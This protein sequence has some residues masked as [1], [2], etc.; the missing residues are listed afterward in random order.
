MFSID[1]L[2]AQPPLSLIF[3]IFLIFG[4]DFIGLFLLKKF[5]LIN[6]K[7]LE[8][9]RYQAPIVGAMLL[10]IIF[11]P[12][13]LVNLTPRLFFQVNA[14][15]LIILGAFQILY[16]LGPY[17]LFLSRVNRF[18]R[19]VLVMSFTRK[20]LFFML[21]GMALLAI[22]P[23]TH[24]DALDYHTGVAI[25]IL[26]NGGMPVMPEWFLSR[27]AGNGELLNAIS[28]SVGAE[29]FSSLLQYSSLLSMLSIIFFTRKI[30]WERVQSI[31]SA[32]L[33][34]ILL[35]LTS[36]PILL[37]LISSSKPQLWPIAMIFFGF[38]LTIH[39]YIYKTSKYNLL[40]TYC[41][42]CML[43]MTASQAKFN[44]M[45]DGAIIGLLGF[46]LMI[47][48]RY[49]FLALIIS[50][51]AV[52]IILVPPIIWKAF[53]YNSS[54]IDS[55]LH[56]LP[57]HLPGTDELMRIIQYSSDSDSYFFFPI[58]IMIPSSP[59]TLGTML[60]IGCLLFFALRPEKYS[61]LKY[62]VVAALIVIILNVFLGPRSARSYLAPYIW[63]LYILSLQ[64]KKLYLKKY[65]WLKWP[66]YLQAFVTT[67]SVYYGVLI[68]TPGAFISAWRT[69]I[70]EL[71]APGYEVMKWAD[72][73]LPKNAVLLNTHRSMALSPRD[74]V[75][76]E[77]GYTFLGNAN[78]NLN[79]ARSK[80]YV[81]R[82]KLKN[83]DYILIEGPIN[84]N[85][86]LSKC[87][88]ETFAGP[89]ITPS[90]QR[91]PFNHVTMHEAWILKFKSY[92][93]PGCAT[94]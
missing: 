21:F 87:Y 77:G 52:S 84:H 32:G 93:L 92:K 20:L 17:S 50:I 25:A 89:H 10:A 7:Y 49:F 85:S 94:K 2:I 65:I 67:A 81:D 90:V 61:F 55:L 48:Q 64:P 37:F 51:L 40:A 78:L 45:L 29:Q 8:W 76:A 44:Y 22:G 19:A 58:S 63:L 26:N 80:I 38:A 12:L 30:K 57:G 39:F 71:H 24:P 91:N 43:V 15:F 86:S 69:N 46:L 83:P 68:L 13:A 5:R 60:G 4:C 88:G 3:S 31:N 36:S 18:Y 28:M 41:L 62:G 23:I 53:V 11:Y 82:I 34:L 73:V 54:W 47:Q 33:D 66:I 27:L 74:S 59:G 9:A 35:A 79:D 56:P 14:I 16:I 72:K 75:A 6:F 70:M 42:I 1:Q